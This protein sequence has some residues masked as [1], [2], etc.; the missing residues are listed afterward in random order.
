MKLLRSLSKDR[1]GSAAIEFAILA[2]PFFV[3]IFAIAEIAVMYFVDSGLDAALHKAVRSVRVGVASNG[4]WDS[5]KFKDVVC[6]ELSFS[7][8]CATKLKV[9][10]TVITNMASITKINPITGGSLAITEDFNLGVSGSYVLV[11]AYLPWNPTFKLY[12]VS[13]ARLADGSYLLGSAELI[14]NEPF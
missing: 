3:V 2:L 8:G 7:F 6:G 13:S 14:K 5:K 11:Q 4:N 12:A 1:K 9:R 10:A